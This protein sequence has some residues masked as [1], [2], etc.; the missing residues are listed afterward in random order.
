MGFE[1]LQA[2]VYDVFAERFE[3]FK[4]QLRQEGYTE[5]EADELLEQFIDE[6]LAVD[7]D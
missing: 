2:E 3:F 6:E 5:A 1:K 7:A 4:H